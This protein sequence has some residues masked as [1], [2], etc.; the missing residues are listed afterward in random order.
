[1]TEDRENFNYYSSIQSLN[2]SNHML[3]EKHKLHPQRYT[4]D[5]K[6][7]K[8]IIADNKYK[9][10]NTYFDD[11][12]HP[13]HKWLPDNKFVFTGLLLLLAIL[14]AV[15]IFT[16]KN[17]KRMLKLLWDSHLNRLQIL[18]IFLFVAY[19][20]IFYPPISYMVVACKIG[21]YTMIIALCAYLQI[22]F[23]PF[24]ITHFFVYF[25]QNFII[26]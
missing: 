26:I 13:N 14:T 3:D 17:R 9:S 6:K 15:N 2:D 21:L 5:Y 11:R 24:W 1:M 12:P 7:F 18:A 16:N 20:F 23:I 22:P 25:S 10:G 8:G 4:D 19:A